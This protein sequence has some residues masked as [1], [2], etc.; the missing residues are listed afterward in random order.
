[1]IDLNNF[2]A[3]KYYLFHHI[4]KFYN[5]IFVKYVDVGSSHNQN[6]LIKYLKSFLKIKTINFDAFDTFNDGD[7]LTET[8]KKVLSDKKKIINFYENYQPQTSSVYPVSDEFKKIFYKNF[9]GRK[10]KNKTQLESIALDDLNLN[11]INII[12]ID[13]QGYNY[14]ILNGAK[15]TLEKNFPILIIEGWN[16]DIYQQD[17]NLGDQISFLNKSG[18]ILLDIESSHS[19]SV[20]NNINLNFSKKIYVGCEM[21]F[22]KKDLL[23]KNLVHD[24]QSMNNVLSILI[25]LDIYGFKSLN[26]K[27]IENQNFLDDN[28]KKNLIN[29]Y[30]QNSHRIINFLSNYKI[31]RFLFYKLFKF[32]IDGIFYHY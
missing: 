18:Y 6:L 1:M 2:I 3:Q 4:N 26:L 30:S 19:W 14:E 32:K 5:P 22:I 9:Q 28:L 16:L 20:P 8:Y 24:E 15:K 13:T 29:F 17:F 21:I 12:K 31:F 11:E 23:F 25:F 7:D 27:I 10:T